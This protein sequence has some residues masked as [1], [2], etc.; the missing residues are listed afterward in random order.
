MTRVTLI[1]WTDWEH[2]E[3]EG[4]LKA[5]NYILAWKH[6]AAKS[7]QGTDRPARPTWLSSWQQ[8]RPATNSMKFGN[9]DPSIWR[10]RN[11]EMLCRAVAVL[12]RKWK[13]S[14]SLLFSTPSF[15][16][17]TN[18]FAIVNWYWLFFRREY[19]S[20]DV[21]HVIK[22]HCTFWIQCLIPNICRDHNSILLSSRAKVINK[23]MLSKLTWSI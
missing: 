14:C 17:P 18:T 5:R 10:L 19:L 8:F 9:V 21:W 12:A 23:K 6:N 13:R 3:E 16:C 11:N 22:N 2:E 4:R 15:P 7:Q 1:A 20:K